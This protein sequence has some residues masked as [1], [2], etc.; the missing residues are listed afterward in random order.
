MK[1]RVTGVILLV[2]VVLLAALEFTESPIIGKSNVV[3]EKHGIPVVYV[4]PEGELGGPLF[5]EWNVTL[6][7]MNKTQYAVN[8]LVQ[9]TVLNSSDASVKVGNAT[10]VDLWVVNETGSK[11]LYDYLFNETYYEWVGNSS[12]LPGV[13]T[14]AKGLNVGGFDRYLVTFERVDYDGNYTVALINPHSFVNVANVSLTIEE[15]WRL[16]GHII[17]PNILSV[18]VTV[19]L[20][21]SG[22]YMAVK[23]PSWL[24][25]EAKRRR[26]RRR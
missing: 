1:W 4:Y 21:F 12:G 7:P 25:K 14:Y 5:P 23:N 8:A 10:F 15:T 22:V 3:F 20:A 19:L 17:E 26:R 6:N 24:S 9:A 2:L 13:E 11:L 18:P 16:M